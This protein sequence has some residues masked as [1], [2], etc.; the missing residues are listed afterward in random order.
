ML[1]GELVAIRDGQAD[2]L[3]L[4]ER[5]QR[6]PSHVVP[7]FANAINYVVFDLLYYRGRSL[8][9][10]SLSERR[11]MLHAELTEMPFVT[12]C[13]GVTGDGRKAFLDAVARGFE[14]VVAKR[15]SSR[16]LPNRRGTAWRKIKDTQELPCAVIGYRAGAD[17][18]RDL[19]VAAMV[20]G[21]PAFVGSVELGIRGGRELLER[22]N[23][24]RIPRPAVPCSL[25]A[26]W[27]TPE[28]ACT[29]RFCGWR[30][31]QVGGMRCWCDGRKHWQG[32]RVGARGPLLNRD[33]GGNN[34]RTLPPHQRRGSVQR[35]WVEGRRCVGLS[36]NDQ[37]FRVGPEGTPG[38]SWGWESMLVLPSTVATAGRAGLPHS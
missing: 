21:R 22:L 30:R 29:V 4:M 23:A 34:P 27:V 13:E 11:R 28:M 33:G 36:S 31:G 3:A 5:H 9:E 18:L 20:D 25:A 14:G 26:R 37:R 24:I 12:L 19:L 17:G 10:R 38:S 16:Y 32:A 8:L 35:L 6:R 15:L 7:F 2:F 1:D